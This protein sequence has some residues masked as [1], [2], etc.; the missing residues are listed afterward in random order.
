MEG[1]LKR[2]VVRTVDGQVKMLEEEFTFD[3]VEDP[4]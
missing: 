1:K 4:I 3:L 2:K